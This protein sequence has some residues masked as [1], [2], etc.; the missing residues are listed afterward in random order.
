MG[1]FD[2]IPTEKEIKEFEECLKASDTSSEEL[3]NLLTTAK[4]VQ[5]EAFSILVETSRKIAIYEHL[6]RIKELQRTIFFEK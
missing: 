2:N 5:K 3:I 6:L 1:V 4:D